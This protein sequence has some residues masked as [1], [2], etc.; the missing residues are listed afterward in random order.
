MN[1]PFRMGFSATTRSRRSINR[2]ARAFL[3][4]TRGDLI[5]W[6]TLHE[7]APR[8]EI[9]LR[10]VGYP[11]ASAG[12]RFRFAANSLW[13]DETFAPEIGTALAATAAS[14]AAPILEESGRTVVWWR[15]TPQVERLSALMAR[16]AP[17]L[18][19]DDRGRLWHSLASMWQTIGEQAGDTSKL[20]NAVTAWHAALEERPRDRVPLNWA[21]TQT[22]LGGAL[23]ALGAR[24]AGTA[25]LG[26]AVAAYRAALEE[27]TRDRVPLNWATTQN[28]LGN[29]LRTLGERETGT[30][31]LEEAV[32]AYRAA[33]EE[34]TR[35][36]VP[37]NWATS[38]GNQGVALLGL[39]ERRADLAQARAA[40]RQIE[41]ARDVLRDGGHAPFADYYEAQIPEAQAL[42]AR[43]G[44]VG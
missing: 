16:H 25:R 22:N 1:S 36:R 23:Q 39:A 26:E 21:M 19:S 14:L 28:N 32:A 18:R 29:A 2:R 10:F 27:R 24:E 37:L 5:L 34:R 9:E 13:L 41:A 7:L 3:R 31:R 15:L 43:L 42:I 8:S 20:E 12:D 6:G 40:L 11:A 44:G 38:S 30:A 33:L 17:N 4:K 35:D